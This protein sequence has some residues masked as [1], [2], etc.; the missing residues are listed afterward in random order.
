VNM[1]VC[2]EFDCF[3]LELVQATTMMLA[4]SVLHK[5]TGFP[6]IPSLPPLPC[7]QLLGWVQGVID[8]GF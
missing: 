3:A 2:C 4:V 7:T 8:D 6:D 5:F 1:I